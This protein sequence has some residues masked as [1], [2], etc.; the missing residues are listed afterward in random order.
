MKTQDIII[1]H[2]STT[3]QVNVIKAFME[4]LKVKFDISKSIDNPYN[5]DFVAK[6]EK[7]RKEFKNGDFISVK[8]EGLENF[9]G[10]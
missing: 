7:S 3:E 5:L 1:A 8:Q 4:A 6:M 2:P 10:L 9:L